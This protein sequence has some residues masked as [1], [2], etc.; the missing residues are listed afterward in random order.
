MTTRWR[1][2]PSA[3][4]SSRGSTTP[5]CSRPAT[6]ATSRPSPTGSRPQL[7]GGRCSSSASWSHPSGVARTSRQPAL[8]ASDSRSCRLRGGVPVAA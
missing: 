7:A 2:G 4:R 1:S 3:T 6:A 5:S 8:L